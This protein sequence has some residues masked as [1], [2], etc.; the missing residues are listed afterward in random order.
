MWLSELIDSSRGLRR[1]GQRL[2]DAGDEAI[3]E[4]VLQL[5]VGA[6]VVVGQLPG[7]GKVELGRLDLHHLVGGAHHGLRQK[8]R[9][10]LRLRFGSGRLNWNRPRLRLVVS[11][12][13]ANVHRGKAVGV[14]VRAEGISRSCGGWRV[15]FQ[16][17]IVWRARLSARLDGRLVEETAAGDVWS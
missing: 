12:G 17:S 15:S 16:I 14:A 7:A 9:L 2:L 4:K 10:R 1:G 11:I 5:L 8:L 6:A 3:A 13:V